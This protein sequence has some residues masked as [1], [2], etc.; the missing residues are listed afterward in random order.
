MVK[1][2]CKVCK[3]RVHYDGFSCQ[4]CGFKID[5]VEPCARCRDG[6]NQFIIKG[7]C[8][9]CSGEIT[10]PQKLIHKA[11]YDMENGIGIYAEESTVPNI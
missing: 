9:D 1:K 8:L 7:L 2:P 6:G 11:A 4:R 3:L 5:K 10:E